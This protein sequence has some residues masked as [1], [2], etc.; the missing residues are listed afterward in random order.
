MRYSKHKLV[1][2]KLAWAMV[3]FMSVKLERKL[4]KLENEIASRHKSLYILFCVFCCFFFA[5]AVGIRKNNRK[6]HEG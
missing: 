5:D 4:G 2:A 1:R 6:S 3:E